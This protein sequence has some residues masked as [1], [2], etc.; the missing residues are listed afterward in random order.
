MT[1]AILLAFPDGREEFIDDAHMHGFRDEH[2]LIARG[3][4]GAGLDAGGQG[5]HVLEPGAL[6]VHMRG[7]EPHAGRFGGWG[8]RPR[9]GSERDQGPARTALLVPEV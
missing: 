1:T 8:D 3:D 6:G 4:P 7:S 5:D 2:L 9:A